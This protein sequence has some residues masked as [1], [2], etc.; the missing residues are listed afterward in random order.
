MNSNRT[1]RFLGNSLVSAII[2]A[3][4]GFL[5]TSLITDVGKEIESIRSGVI[6]LVA[7]SCYGFMALVLFRIDSEDEFRT[8]VMKTMSNPLIKIDVEAISDFAT[9]LVKKSKYVRV[10]GMAKQDILCDADRKSASKRY[11]TKLEDMLSKDS[12]SEVGFQYYRVL[13]KQVSAELQKHIST[14]ESNS[15][16]HKKNKFAAINPD[17][18]FDFY[19]S[20]QI[21]D[22]SDML[23]IVDNPTKMDNNKDDNAL[24]FWTQDKETI[25][26][27]TKRFDSAWSRL[28]KKK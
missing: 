4:I 22:Q 11:L 17:N 21:F 1:K 5:V 10:V 19:I 2:G 15:A 9:S 6:L 13:P 14:C 28:G 23:L 3:I 20:Y 26:V 25:E 12:G 18:D 27:F 8:E 7:L 16:S 24:C